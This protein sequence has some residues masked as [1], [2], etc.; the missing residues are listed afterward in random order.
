[1]FCQ[2]IF[3]LK[4]F[5]S[6]YF[7]DLLVMIIMCGETPKFCDDIHINI[8]TLINQIT[9]ERVFKT[10]SIKLVYRV[11][12]ANN[13]SSLRVLSLINYKNIPTNSMCLSLLSDHNYRYPQ[14]LRLSTFKQPPPILLLF[15]VTL[16][17]LSHIFNNLLS[18]IYT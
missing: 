13:Q 16:H 1:M 17:L 5:V 2:L 7:R 11:N 12:H 10:K 9:I 3:F 14:R 4:F 8:L 18:L 15:E 6:V